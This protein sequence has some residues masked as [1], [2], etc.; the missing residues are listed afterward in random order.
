MNQALIFNDDYYF[1]KEQNVWEC[2]VQLSGQ[3]IKIILVSNKLN[4][5]SLLD[6]GTKFDLEEHVEYWC[7]NNEIEGSIITINLN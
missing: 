6:A 2:S 1:D 5:L 4:A 7:E 3:K